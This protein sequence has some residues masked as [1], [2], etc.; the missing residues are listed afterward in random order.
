MD[1]S[2]ETVC[3]IDYEQRQMRRIGHPG[4]GDVHEVF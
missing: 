2:P 1:V 4:G 3:D